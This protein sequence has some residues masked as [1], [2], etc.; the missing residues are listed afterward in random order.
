MNAAP[1]R[2]L[3]ICGSLRA[4][5]YNARALAAARALAPPALGFVEGDLADI[6]LYNADVERAE[7]FPAPVERLRQQLADSDAVL[8]ATPEYNFSIPGVL[9]NAIDWLSRP[10][11]SPLDGAV[12][13]IIGAGGGGGTARAQ[14]HLRTVLVHNR[15]HVVPG[16]EVLI[17]RARQHFDTDGRLVD[18]AIAG[19]LGQLLEAL[20]DLTRRLR[21]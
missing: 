5:S 18:E 13:A 15:V 2:V 16:P 14:M 10:P 1:L 21:A 3:T 9:K 17:R 20:E 6:P 12:A 4:G 7:G 19:R 11:D 8:I